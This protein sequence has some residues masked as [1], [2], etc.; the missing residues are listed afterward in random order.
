MEA[1]E[2]KKTLRRVAHSRETMIIYN[3]LQFCNGGKNK[4][5][6]I[7]LERAIV[8]ASKAVGKSERM[9]KNIRRDFENAGKSEEESFQA[10]KDSAWEEII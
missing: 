1:P 7:P 10:Q 6:I 4:G 2:E 8:R 9:V 3:V 5:F